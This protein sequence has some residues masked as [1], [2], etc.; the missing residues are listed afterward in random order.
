[1]CVCVFACYVFIFVFFLFYFT[2]N[3]SVAGL[4]VGALRSA[5]EIGA[6]KSY[7]HS[8]GSQLVHQL[9]HSSGIIPSVAGATMGSGQSRKLCFL[10][11]VVFCCYAVRG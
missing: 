2:P 10:G 11:L 6:A 1:M 9:V 4:V 3:K 8:T 7:G 5:L